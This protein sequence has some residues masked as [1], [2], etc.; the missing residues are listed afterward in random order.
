MQLDDEQKDEGITGK[1]EGRN[2]FFHEGLSPN[3]A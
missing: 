3:L 2:I 1:Q